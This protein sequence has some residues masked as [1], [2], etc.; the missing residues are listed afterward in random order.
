MFVVSYVIIVAFHPKLKMDRAI[1]KRSF[2]HSLEKL[3]TIDYS[4]N[5][6]LSFIDVNLVKKLKDS[7]LNVHGKKCKNAIAKMFSTEL[8]LVKKTILTWFNQKI[9]SQHPEIC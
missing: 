1:I 6:Q 9:K 3:T 8:S 7:V 5:D 4:T 2:E